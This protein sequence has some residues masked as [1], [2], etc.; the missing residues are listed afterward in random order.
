MALKRVTPGLTDTTLVTGK[1]IQYT[2]VDLG[3]NAK[4]GAEN[5]QG[6][7]QGDVYKK[8]DNAAVIQ[9]VE[10]ILLTNHYEKPF[11]LFYG[12]NLRAMLFETVENYSET[13]VREMITNAIKRDEPRVEVVDVVF[14]DGSTAIER[15]VQ[16][17]RDN[18]RNTVYIKVEFRIENSD[19]T[20]TAS[21]NMNRLR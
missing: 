1:K 7:M 18:F 2:D 6:V 10:N 20:F 3:F 14:Y 21:V 17:L 5:E 12:A 8:T 11:N 9:A 19:G 15:G 13:L 4:P 16:S